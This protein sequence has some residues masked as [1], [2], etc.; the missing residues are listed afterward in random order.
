MVLR[1]ALDRDPQFLAGLEIVQ[2]SD[3]YRRIITPA[4]SKASNI[5]LSVSV[6]GVMSLWGPGAERAG[7]RICASFGKRSNPNCRVATG[8][9][10]AGSLT[11]IAN[12]ATSRPRL[13]LAVPLH[14]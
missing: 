11:R 2:D 13:S 7:R 6:H 14:V 3:M 10:N 1:K 4:D 9:T 8:N 5:E 12:A